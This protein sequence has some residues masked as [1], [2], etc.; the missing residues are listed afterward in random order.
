LIRADDKI[1]TEE[2]EDITIGNEAAK[3]RHI[4]ELSHPI[5]NGIVRD[6]DDMELVW[7]HG[8]E[9]VQQFLRKS[10]NFYSRWE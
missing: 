6:W 4:L 7:R 8:F 1:N 9:N 3:K 5:K 2:V 10:S